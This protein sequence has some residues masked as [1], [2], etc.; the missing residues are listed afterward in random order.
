M[1][2]YF[3]EFI[4]FI[5][6]NMKGV[7]SKL[8][9]LVDKIG[10]DYYDALQMRL[11]KIS[12]EPSISRIIG[13]YSYKLAAIPGLL[14]VYAC[15]DANENPYGALGIGMVGLSASIHDD[16]IDTRPVNPAAYVN[17]GD[18]LLTEGFN[19]FVS[20]CHNSPNFT[21][22]YAALA[23]Y[24]KRMWEC[25]QMDMEFFGR[26]KVSKKEYLQNIARSRHMMKLGLVT[27]AV[28]TGQKMREYEII[29][30][31][32]GNILQILDDIGEVQEDKGN[33]CTY[34]SCNIDR[35]GPRITMDIAKKMMRKENERLAKYL[36]DKPSLLA[37][38][39]RL[40]KTVGKI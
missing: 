18:V 13:K 3:Y 19:I 37:F 27:A 24:A 16:V 1:G 15:D 11:K 33:Y 36:Q 9:Q 25:Q 12:V 5:A 2:F 22:A 39:K 17:A 10:R 40:M 20:E 14:F 6:D 30:D 23:L 31:R 28:L 21:D 34:F 7:S 8:N 29:S 4:R 32:F 35:L 38:D 26:S